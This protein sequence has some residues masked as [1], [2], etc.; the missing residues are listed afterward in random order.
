MSTLH[1]VTDM[2]EL[3]IFWKS[4]WFL[5]NIWHLINSGP[6]VWHVF[7][8]SAWWRAPWWSMSS[9]HLL[10]WGPWVHIFIGHRLVWAPICGSIMTYIHI[11]TD[12][13]FSTSSNSWGEIYGGKPLV[14]EP[15]D[16]LVRQ[17]L[18]HAQGGGEAQ[19]LVITF[20]KRLFQE[21]QVFIWDDAWDFEQVR[22]MKRKR[23][24][25]S[26]AIIRFLFRVVIIW[27]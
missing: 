4:I 15:R 26:V 14:L 19:V 20:K 8:T 10:C 2:M 5:N 1:N 21:W 12:S 24:P 17:V 6:E 18:C 13:Y 11:I 23:V 16:L 9:L 22:S 27:Y 25:K 3:S 7:E